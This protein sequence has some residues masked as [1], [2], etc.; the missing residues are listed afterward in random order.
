MRLNKDGKT[1]ALI[2]L[3]GGI[4]AASLKSRKSFTEGAGEEP[5]IRPPVKLTFGDIMQALLETKNA[6]GD[7]N[8][9]VL[10]AG[11]AYYATLAFFPLLA[12]SVAIGA[13]LITTEQLQALAS[14]AETYLPG[15]VSGIVT[16]QLER[17]VSRRADNVLAAVI[18]IAIALFSASGASK[19]LVTASNVAYGVE[20]SRGWLAQQAWGIVWTV[21]SIAFGFTVISLL[22]FDQGVLQYLGVP[23]SVSS[24][25]IYVRWPA[26]VLMLIFGLAIFYRF[27][28]NRTGARWQW[29]SWGAIIA[30]VV[31]LVATVLFFAY[32]RNV[33][34]FDQSYSLFAGIVILMIWLNLSAL[35]VLLGAEMNHRL[36]KIGRDK[37]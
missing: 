13:L 9:T 6:L 5:V 14:V 16:E 35:I 19:T 7:K 27:G 15:D 23:G 26:I 30:T 25:L 24:V 1:L 12:A 36:E 18:A 17:L 4:L 28:P 2:G 29:V 34:N 31:W 11:V 10:S 22:A 37:A 33:G 20:E 8:L 21:G 3:L 32:V